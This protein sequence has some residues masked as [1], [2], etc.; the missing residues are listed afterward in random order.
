MSETR[1][2]ATPASI[3]QIEGQ[4]QPRVASKPTLMP[5]L[6]LIARLVTLASLIVSL[7]VMV[8]DSEKFDSRTSLH[9]NDIYSYRYVVATCVIGIVYNLSQSSLLIYEVGSG[10]KILNHPFPHVIFIGDKVILCLL[11]TGV[12]AAFG[13]TI[14]LKSEIDELEDAFED[15]VGFGFPSVRA[16]LDDFFNRAYIPTIFLLIALLT[17]GVSSVLSSLALAKR[18]P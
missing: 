13:V 8:S 3:H 11:A 12:G 10:K 17:C 6:A 5:L 2:P 18:T 16:K 9:F 4:T 7:S 14:D 1:Q 15:H